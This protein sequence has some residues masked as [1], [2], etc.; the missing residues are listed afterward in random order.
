MA[1][2]PEGL[3]EIVTKAARQHTDPAKAL[4]CAEK[5]ARKHSD[6]AS[7]QAGLIRGALLEM[8]YDVRHRQNVAVRR[9]GGEFGT[10]AKVDLS[11]GAVANALNRSPYLNYFISGRCLGDIAGEDL[12]V[13][14]DREREAADTASFHVKLLLRLS[15]TVPQGKSVRDCY[16][17]AK[18]KRL[19]AELQP[20][21]KR[22]AA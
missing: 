18:L 19:F 7:W 6:F 22:K 11:S 16:S 4:D 3:L 13:L 10:P 20:K 21:S 14:A 1:T 15:A 9:S 8:I 2:V 5:S 17:E 12:S